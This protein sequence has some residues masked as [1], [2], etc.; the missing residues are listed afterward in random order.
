MKNKLI[1]LACA[2]IVMVLC[3][4]QPL[5]VS[6]ADSDVVTVSFKVAGEGVSSKA[7][8]IGNP[9]YD[10]NVI[11]QYKAIPDFKLDNGKK[12][13]G[14]TGDV[15]TDFPSAYNG[16][17]FELRFSKGSWSFDVRGVDKDDSSIVLFRMPSKL[18]FSLASESTQQIIVFNVEKTPEGFGTACLNIIA[19]TDL[20]D[21]TLVVEYNRIGTDKSYKYTFNQ[22][23]DID[24][25]KAFFAA[26][27]N[28]PSGSY[29]MT[30]NYQDCDNDEVLGPF[31]VEIVNKKDT[32]VDGRIALYAPYGF[33]MSANTTKGMTRY[34]FDCRA[35]FE[36]TID[37]NV[38][39]YLSKGNLSITKEGN[40]ALN[41][42]P[43]AESQV[44][45]EEEAEKEAISK[46]L[47]VINNK[48]E[49]AQAQVKQAKALTE[50]QKEAKRVLI[51]KTLEQKI[52]IPNEF[53]KIVEKQPLKE[54]IRD[55]MERSEGRGIIFK[56]NFIC[57]GALLQDDQVKWGYDYTNKRWDFSLP[58]RLFNSS[59]APSEHILVI[60][61][62]VY[63]TREENEQEITELLFETES[64]P[65]AIHLE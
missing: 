3:A 20:Q 56:Y 32:I 46:Q 14:S 43:F 49:K 50:A 38:N 65:I 47:L 8:T 6:S 11:F 44:A 55:E 10:S 64:E 18:N 54:L 62:S 45:K 13:V 28:L 30:F 31:E 2:A 24:K 57:D 25:Y 37:Q 27:L 48:A 36:N 22:P 1:L 52:E 53:E 33:E 19:Q 21:G 29:I 61:A 35:H 9:L 5:N 58:S 12:P 16:S 60:K 41:P 34:A 39:F 40:Y 26:D 15:W 63:M 23:T 7:I 17:S 4:C 51:E 59:I 42:S